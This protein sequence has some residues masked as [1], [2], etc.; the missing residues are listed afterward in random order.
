M[1]DSRKLSLESD[2]IDMI[3]TSPPYFNIQTYA[4]CNWLRLWFLGYNYKE[5]RKELVQTG[6]EE[7]WEKFMYDSLKELNRVLKDGSFCFIV[8]GNIKK[9]R[10]NMT[11]YID[12][13]EFLSEVIEKAGFSIENVIRDS[14][15]SN[16]R[17]L[18]YIPDNC[19]VKTENIICLKK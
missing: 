12:T 16:R 4:W 5:V 13:V 2:S 17:V 19:G 8:I 1:E 6:S 15:P 14:I 3:F 9:K 7:K 18:T 10:A 11:K